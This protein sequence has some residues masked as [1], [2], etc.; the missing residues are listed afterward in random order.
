LPEAKYFNRIDLKSGYHQIQIEDLDVRKTA[1]QMR[2]GS[3]EFLVMPFELCN[4]PAT[5][6][7]IMNSIFYDEMV[8]CV[9]VYIDDILI[10]S[11][12][13]QDHLHDVR[14]VLEKLH[15]HKLMA[16]QKKSEFFLEKIDFLGHVLSTN[17]I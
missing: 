10:Y 5:F 8:E 6:T 3:Y 11:K 4:A 13:V 14:K 16:N 9:V 17:G 12:T 1:M 7:T 15:A 2:Y